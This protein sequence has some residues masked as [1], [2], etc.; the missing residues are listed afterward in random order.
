VA[1]CRQQSQSTGAQAPPGK[2]SKFKSSDAGPR[3]NFS[4]LKKGKRKGSALKGNRGSG[5]GGNHSMATG[6]GPRAKK[7]GLIRPM[8]GKNRF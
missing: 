5:G 4:G 6:G 1:I 2:G 7:A 8:A 3:R